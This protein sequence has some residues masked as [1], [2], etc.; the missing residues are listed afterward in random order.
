MFMEGS[1]LNKKSIKEIMRIALY[2]YGAFIPDRLYLKLLYYTH[3]GKKL[4]LKNPQT[5]N[6]KL[7]WLKL[8]ERDSLHTTLVDKIEVKKWVAEKIGDEYIIPTLGIWSSTS[9][10]QFD[11]LPDRFVLKTNH[12]SGGLYI[13]KDKTNLMNIWPEVSKRITRSLNTDYYKI[14]R[15]WPYKNVK[16]KVFAEALLESDQID[17]PDYKFF[18]FDGVPKFLFVA[19]ERQKECEDVKFD[20]FDTSFTHLPIKHGHQNALYPPLKPENYERMLNIASILSRGFKHVRVDLYNINGK[21]YFGE[22]TFFHHGGFVP[23]D[24]DEW[25]RTFGNY[26]KLV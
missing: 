26:I 15:E 5:Y 22:L 21:I 12:D 18:C 23:F 8:N 3:F 20:F 24:P 7:Q 6:E 13:C 1:I 25:D 19:T 10:I 11:Q 2:N 9:E 14:G 17:I 4:N 16:R